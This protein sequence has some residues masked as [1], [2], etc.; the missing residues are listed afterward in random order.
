MTTKHAPKSKHAS[1]APPAAAAPV[2]TAAPVAVVESVPPPGPVA[3]SDPV[4][5]GASAGVVLEVQG[6]DR[7][8]PTEQIHFLATMPV[9]TRRGQYVGGQKYLADIRPFGS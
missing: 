8:G 7:S 1:E 5:L 9:G 4:P 3:P 6:I 2:E